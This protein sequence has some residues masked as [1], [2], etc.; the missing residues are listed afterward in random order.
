MFASE[1]K[2]RERLPDF[3]SKDELLPLLV[4]LENRRNILCYGKP[5]TK[6]YIEKALD[7]FYEIRRLLD[8]LGVRYE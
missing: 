3:P 6:K 8:R 1:K 2:A 4:A 5:Q 7:L